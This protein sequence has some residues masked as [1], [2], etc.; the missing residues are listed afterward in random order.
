MVGGVVRRVDGRGGTS[1]RQVRLHPLHS[2]PPARQQHFL[3]FDLSFMVT[4]VPVPL[5]ILIY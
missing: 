5:M 2:L 4:N 1:F 3:I